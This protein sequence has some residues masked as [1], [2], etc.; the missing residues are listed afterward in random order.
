MGVNEETEIVF[1]ISSKTEGWKALI[2]NTVTLGVGEKTTVYLSIQPPR[3]FGYHYDIG[4]II[5][6]ATPTRALDTSI[7]GEPKPV[8]VQVESNGFSLLGAELVIVPLIII[9][10]IL[11]LLYRYV[12]KPRRMK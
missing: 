6:E 8:S 9:V 1:D 7:R 11:F 5:V 2:T 12:I 3:S 10:V 4:D